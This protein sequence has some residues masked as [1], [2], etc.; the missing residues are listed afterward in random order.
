PVAAFATTRLLRPGGLGEPFA[1]AEG[2]MLVVRI[3]G[4]LPTRT[5]G[6]I[7]STGQL[8]FEPISRRVR[9]QPTEEPFGEGADAMFIAKGFGLIVVAPR[10]AQFTA[11][12]L[13][14]DIVYVREA[15]LFSFEETLHWENG[16]VPGGG[17]DSMRVVQFRGN[18][19]IVMRAQRAAF[20]L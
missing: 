14:D 15:A 5:F 8:T 13:T 3:D 20:S 19:R 4:R 11:L 6:A 7:A 1:L 17:P 9:G 2:G 16:R 10:G 12:Q 18:G